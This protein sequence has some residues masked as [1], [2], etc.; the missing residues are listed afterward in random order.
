M[1]HPLV[2]TKHRQYKQKT[3][4]LFVQVDALAVLQHGG[5][6]CAVNLKHIKEAH[7]A[8]VFHIPVKTK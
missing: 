7:H 3:Y 2:S 8:G 4:L 5:K 1:K 6:G